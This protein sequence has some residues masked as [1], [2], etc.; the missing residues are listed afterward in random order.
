MLFNLLTNALKFTPEEGSITL[1]A[2]LHRGYLSCS[3][4]DTGI[5]IPLAQ[6]SRIFDK[7]AQS[8]RSIAPG[9]TGSGLGLAIARSLVEMHHGKIS[10]ESEPGR[11]SR[12]TFT[13]PDGLSRESIDVYLRRRTLRQDSPFSLLGIRLA[14][15][16]P[17]KETLRDKF[18]PFIDRLTGA[19][20]DEL[21]PR[22]PIWTLVE[23]G[24]WIGLLEGAKGEEGRQRCRQTRRNLERYRFLQ[25]QEP[26]S[27]QLR[28]A[29]V[30]Y[31]E[32]V[33]KLSGILERLRGSL[34]E[35]TTFQPGEL[36]R[37][38]LVVDDDPVITDFLSSRLQSADIEPLV[39]HNGL[40]AVE[41]AGE[42]L[43]DLILLDI[44]LPGMDGYEVIA[45][46]KQERATEAI[47]VIFL[48]GHPI[49]T[50]KLKEVADNYIPIL[51]KPF[52]TDNLFKAIA[53][54]LS[55]NHISV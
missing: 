5:G 19:I 22:I 42:E 33:G 43:P 47:P 36:K 14:N 52:P 35:Q 38:I 12:F 6:Q 26:I 20:C 7:F 45:R 27:L 17:L 54:T 46:L 28:V 37:R 10:V 40:Q 34:D 32:D 8:S 3:V 50:T 23:D 2:G 48:S 1:E 13:I 44:R 9:V 24:E 16:Q 18:P 53:Q 39:A 25:G 41:V 4:A 49:D 31:P 29:S 11:G 30:S 55:L 51:E 15:Y 21:D